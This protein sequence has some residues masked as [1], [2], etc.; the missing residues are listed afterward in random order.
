MST[1]TKAPLKRRVQAQLMGIVNVPMR[2]ILGLPFA[3]PLSGRLMLL[4][5]TGR[6]TGKQYRQPVTTCARATPC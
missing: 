1:R 3:T 5:L 2:R 6:R 4:F